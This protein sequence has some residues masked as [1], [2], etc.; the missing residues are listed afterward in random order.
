MMQFEEIK[1]LRA[2]NAHQLTD[3]TSRSSI[4]SRSMSDIL[5]ACVER[6][7]K[8]RCC[9]WRRPQKLP[10]REN[11]RYTI[12]AFQALDHALHQATHATRIMRIF[13]LFHLSQKISVSYEASVSGEAVGS[14]QPC[15]NEDENDLP[16]VALYV[17]HSTCHA[18]TMGACT[19][20]C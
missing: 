13:L 9:G 15:G 5:P 10:H 4:A 14:L 2:R 11:P 12:L 19:G 18:V 3:E 8:D 7:R 17:E 1:L 20:G 16:R 6:A